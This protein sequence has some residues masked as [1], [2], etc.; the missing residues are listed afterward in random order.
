MIKVADDVI[1]T[2][3]K[4]KTL[5]YVLG[6]MTLAKAVNCNTLS[7]HVTTYVTDQ[8]KI[9]LM[10]YPEALRAKLKES[11]SDAAPAAAT[12]EP[13]VVPAGPDPVVLDRALAVPAAKRMKRR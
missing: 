7:R 10:D 1:A 12:P 6:G 4:A 8:L 13:S 3:A 9:P 2:E 11:K 5:A